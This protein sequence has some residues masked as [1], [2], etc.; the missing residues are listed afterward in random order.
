MMYRESLNIYV[1]IVYGRYTVMFGSLYGFV[2]GVERER[3]RHP[4][5]LR[6]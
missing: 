3:L 4:A 6:K 2:C 1:S 5:V